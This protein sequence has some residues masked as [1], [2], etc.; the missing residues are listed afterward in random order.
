MLRVSL[1][2][3]EEL[4]RLPLSELSDVKALKQ[5]LN[6]QHGL[7]SRF[8]Q[9]LL[10]DGVALHDAVKLDSAM[11]L[12]A[13]I[14]EFNEV[15]E[16]REDLYDAASDCNV[17]EVERLLQLPL[18]P[19]VCDDESGKWCIT[20]LIQASTDG[21]ADVVQLLLE[22][23]ADKELGDIDGCTP[24]FVAA[25]TGHAP[26]V[27]LLLEAGAQTEVRDLKGRTA[28]MEA[29]MRGHTPVVQLLLEAGAQKDARDVEGRTAVMEASR[30][31]HAS[32]RQLLV[33][34]G[35]E[36]PKW[37]SVCVLS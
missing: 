34:A 30:N 16:A 3:G 27:R 8:R 11:D 29:S 17:T 4:A 2:S 9:R 37:T 15:V 23:G 12:Q 36:L 26:V 1:L 21:H 25:Q 13:V 31:G 7:P 33:D 6:Q 20:L 32:V 18:D 24:L 10:H 28:L 5:R 35:A 14:M 19:D 22:A